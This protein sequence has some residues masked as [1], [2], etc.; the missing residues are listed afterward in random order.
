MA[1]P[2]LQL[3]RSV[4]WDPPV[5]WVLAAHRCARHTG[6]PVTLHYMIPTAP[7]CQHLKPMPQR[8]TPMAQL[9]IQEGLQPEPAT[10]VPE[11]K[12]SGVLSALG[13]LAPPWFPCWLHWHARKLNWTLRVTLCDD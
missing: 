6:A 1:F 7:P 12:L 3:P 10:F 2:T 5:R 11:Q 9:N 4:W 8:V 13:K